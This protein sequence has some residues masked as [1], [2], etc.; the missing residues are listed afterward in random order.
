MVDWQERE[1]QQLPDVPMN[2]PPA[3]RRPASVPSPER[4]ATRP[5]SSGRDSPSPAYRDR[6]HGQLAKQLKIIIIKLGKLYTHLEHLIFYLNFFFQVYMYLLEKK[7]D[8]NEDH[9]SVFPVSIISLLNV[10]ITF[11]LDY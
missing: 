1:R 3:A 11:I 6:R 7:Y 8:V 9:D 10:N 2:R 5:A 4:V